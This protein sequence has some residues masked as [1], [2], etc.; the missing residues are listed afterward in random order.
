MVLSNVGKFCAFRF[1]G[2]RLSELSMAKGV[3]LSGPKPKPTDGIEPPFLGYVPSVIL[4]TK[5]ADNLALTA[6]R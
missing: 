5:L 1:Q 2:V 3:R 4:K 6:A